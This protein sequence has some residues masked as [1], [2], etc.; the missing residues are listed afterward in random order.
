MNLRYVSSLF[1][2]PNFRHK[3][4]RNF[5]ERE[6]K[7]EDKPPT[8]STAKVSKKKHASIGGQKKKGKIIW[9]SSTKTV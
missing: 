7:L 8:V 6:E 9:S 1:S 4:K 3:K 5:L 2:Y